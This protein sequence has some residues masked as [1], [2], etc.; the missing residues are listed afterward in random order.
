MPRHVPSAWLPR[1]LF[2]LSVALSVILTLLVVFSSLF[3]HEVTPLRG[4]GRV[5]TIFAHDATLRRTA[6]ASALGLLVTAC[7]FFRSAATPRRAPPRNRKL[8]P[9]PNIAG[10]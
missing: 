5:L 9:P 1:W 3:D 10:A 4:W 6:L 2:R 8:P 7:V